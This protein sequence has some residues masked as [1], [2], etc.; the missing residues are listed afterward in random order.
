[1]ARKIA[2]DETPEVAIEVFNNVMDVLLPKTAA[3]ADMYIFTAHQVLKE[4]LD[5]ADNLQRHGFRRSG[6]LVWVKDG[7]GM[8]NLEAWGMGYE[9]ILFLKKGNRPRSNGRRTGILEI[10]QL[11]PSELIHP[12]EK[13]IPLLDELIRHSTS[14][15]DV[16]VDPFAGSAA[17]VRA[18]RAAGRSSI[19]IEL[20]EFNAR[21]AQAKFDSAE[22]SLF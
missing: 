9:F 19:G 13:P 5:V 14:R 1:M 7:P 15:G 16:I 21:T 11:R 2:N 18:A 10:P 6:V 4:W 17:T 22:E 8:G 3:E 12:H 20:D